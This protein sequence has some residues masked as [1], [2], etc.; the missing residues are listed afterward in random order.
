MHIR[1]VIFVSFVSRAL[2]YIDCVLIKLKFGSGTSAL[3]LYV[4]IRGGTSGQHSSLSKCQV[5][6]DKLLI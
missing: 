6:A 5:A 4:R 2:N 1:D 3:T